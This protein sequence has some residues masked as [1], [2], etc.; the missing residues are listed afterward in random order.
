MLVP[1]ASAKDLSVYPTAL[2][3]VSY[4]GLM[5]GSLV[6]AFSHRSLRETSADERVV[7][8][9]SP[10]RGREEGRAWGTGGRISLCVRGEPAATLESLEAARRVQALQGCGWLATYA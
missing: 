10:F 1:S 5:G 9:G 3:Y 8:C 6:R 7:I 2:V 4:S